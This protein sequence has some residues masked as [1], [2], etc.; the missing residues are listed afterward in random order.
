MLTIHFLGKTRITF[1]GC[2]IGE[3]LGTKA[4]ALICLLVLTEHS[5]LSRDKIIG[6]LWP[7]SNGDAARY[8]LRYNL[9]QIKKTLPNDSSGHPFLLVNKETCGINPD[10]DYLSDILEVREFNPWD[11]DDLEAI[12]KLK[13]MF[14]GE[15]LEGCY[16]KGCEAFNEW[17]IFERI[18]FEKI[19]VKILK[20][21]VVLY[22][23]TGNI[24]ACLDTIQDIMEIEPYDE[25]IVEKKLELYEICGNRTAAITYYN[26]FTNHL[27][28][29]LGIEPSESLRDKYNAIRNQAVETAAIHKSDVSGC[30]K[31]TK[32]L[33][34]DGFKKD[35]DHQ[36]LVLKTACLE[37][38]P[39]FWVASVLE[40][41][42]DLGDRSL[43][44]P[45]NA[46]EIICLSS[47]Q[48]R[49]INF[50]EDDENNLQNILPIRDV[51]VIT[52]FLRLI[53]LL[54]QT[55]KIEFVNMNQEVMD[56]ASKQ[57]YQL[58]KRS[59]L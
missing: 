31:C 2:D 48:P 49:F 44:N 23:V 43:F 28:G 57:V 11:N 13:T 47:I 18:N 14:Q 54:A 27:A 50:L 32:C 33:Q 42:I 59:K 46:Q 1:D 4:Y 53:E 55:H 45:L 40:A 7:D 41:I 22:E 12:L 25:K 3:P 6:Y 19:K 52:A 39:Y 8:N 51:A 20:R 17:I 26:W 34:Q 37:G 29:S 30:R 16:F 10:Y 5:H 36:S 35:L 56:S 15:F 38:V 24:D 21:L 58:M 9:W